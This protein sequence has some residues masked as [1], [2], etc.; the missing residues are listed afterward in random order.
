[1]TKYHHFKAVHI[2]KE[3]V[4]F[5]Q[6]DKRITELLDGPTYEPEMVLSE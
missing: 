5:D 4:Y 3:N 2:L 6:V 1:M